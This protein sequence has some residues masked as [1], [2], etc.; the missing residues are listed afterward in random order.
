M[1]GLKKFLGL[2]WMIL[3][4]AM[5]LFLFWQAYE[6]I[7]IA[8]EAVKANTALQ[9]G[10]ILVIFVPISIGLFIFGKYSFNGEYDHLPSSSD[11]L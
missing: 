3:S 6:K 1:N 8:G 2:I 11:E 7:S 10:I 4:P 5:I 9:W